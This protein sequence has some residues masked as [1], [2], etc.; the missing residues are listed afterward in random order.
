MSDIVPKLPW[1]VKEKIRKRFARC[2]D[3]DV[4]IRYL[5]IFN[6]WKGR[7]VRQAV[8]V[9]N[10]RPTTGY[11]IAARFRKYGE[12]GLWDGREGNGPAKLDADYLGLLDQVVRS[13][14]CE[15]GWRRP[16]WTRE[17]LVETLRRKTGIRI[18]V[19]TM[20]RALA[21]I[22]ARHGKPRPRVGC[23]WHPARKTRRLNELHR[24]VEGLSRR[25]VLVYE[26][27]VDVHLNPKIGLDWMGKG[28]QKDV[29]TP[30]QNDKRYLAGAPGC[31]H[32]ANSLGRRRAEEQL[33]VHGSAQEADDRLRAGAGDS[34]DLG[35]LRDS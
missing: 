17:M 11:R 10:I 6:L 20:S 23:P 22:G 7:S 15:H 26:D 33:A 30:G 28:Q 19:T 29:M 13:R 35:Q 14:P 24:L 27:E 34:C 4:R 12:A 8:A 31:P 25:D 2:A 21:R 3:A 16:T 32:A 18:H 5:L 9:L 1:S